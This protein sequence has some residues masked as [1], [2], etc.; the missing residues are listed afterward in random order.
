VLDEP[1]NHLDTPSNERME[2]ALKQ[3]TRPPKKFSTAAGSGR[4]PTG[5]TG[6]GT[7][8][9][10]THDRMLL[11]HIVDQLL[12]L[13]GEGGLTHF[14]GTYREWLEEQEKRTGTA[15]VA[16]SAEK[17]A[18]REKSKKAEPAKPKSAAPK[19]KKSKQKSG[20]AHSH[21]S[22]DKLEAEIEKIESRIRELEMELAKP[23][24]Y[25]D[26]QKF[27]SLQKEHDELTAKLEPL[28]A[29]WTS[30]AGT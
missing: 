8:L 29:E 4:S 15:E 16:K 1:S 22:Q 18:K 5:A 30:R 17:D 27:G 10:I 11:D 20:G 28:E 14:D 13:D 26:R 23:E 2:E 9:L 21:L 12:V 6:E 3:W 25:K 7:L 19:P 24:T